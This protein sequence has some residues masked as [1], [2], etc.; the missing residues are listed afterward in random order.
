M[1]GTVTAASTAPELI[2]TQFSTALEECQITS[3]PAVCESYQIEGRV[4]K[5]VVYPRS[6]EQVAAVL[7]CAADRDLAVVPCRNLTKAAM[8]NPPARYDVALSMKDMNRVWY[9]EP[10]DLVVSA[11]AGMKLG[12]FQHFV[13]GDKL[14]LPLD[15]QGGVRAS[16]GGILAANASGPLRQL[17]GSPR[18]LVL[19]MTIATTEG[20]LVRIGGRVVKNVAGYD[21]GKLLIGS[22]GTLGVIVEASFKLHPL[23]AGRTTFVL[24]C[25]TLAEARDLRCRIQECGLEPLRMALLDQ[26]AA[27]LVRSEI[28]ADR[29]GG[30]ELWMEAAG[31]PR[32]IERYARTAEEMAR[33]GGVRV[34]REQAD[35]A[36]RAGLRISDFHLAIR[37]CYPGLVILRA[38]LPIAISEQ[39]ISQAQQIAAGESVRLAIIALVGVGSVRVYVLEP[40]ESAALPGFVESFRTLAVALGGALIVESCSPELKSRVDVWGPAG[41]DFPI[42][43]SLKQTWDPKGILAPGRLLG[44]L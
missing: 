22:H 9:Y 26:A 1:S 41:D 31:S 28:S 29:I 11:E 43:R 4:P 42:M 13:G 40:P 25:H 21:L 34:H 35:A 8:G 44:G 17:Y 20:K 37:D 15:P 19:G 16:L 18:D 38:A 24:S 32:I 39:F 6:G 12:D 23:P 33:K 10:A 3:K 14:W 2:R 7:K 5:C 30:L 36:E 27:A